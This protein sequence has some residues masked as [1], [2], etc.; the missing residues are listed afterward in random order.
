VILAKRWDGEGKL[1][2]MRIQPDV[3]RSGVLPA[4][5]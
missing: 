5:L 2:G 1:L 4:V 3:E